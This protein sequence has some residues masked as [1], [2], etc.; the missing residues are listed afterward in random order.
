MELHAPQLF[1]VYR[2]DSGSLGLALFD[3]GSIDNLSTVCQSCMTME[4]T[5]LC[6]ELSSRSTAS[7]LAR[8]C[9]D[10]A[11]RETNTGR[12]VQLL[13]NAAWIYDQKGQK[14]KALAVSSPG[15]LDC[16]TVLQ[17]SCVGTP[18]G[19]KIDRGLRL[20]Q[21]V[22]VTYLIDSVCSRP[23]CGHPPSGE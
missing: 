20:Q 10:A 15:G 13:L 7:T 22:N 21:I 8:E 12:K 4:G 5:A 23:C 1:V 6:D 11:A 17:G 16:L 2:H 19:P 3:R 18:H 14:R 9:V